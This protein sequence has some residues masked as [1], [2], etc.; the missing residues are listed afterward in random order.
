MHHYY[1]GFVSV[2]EIAKKLSFSAGLLQELALTGSILQLS[3]DLQ[4]R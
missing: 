2:P 4:N 3:T 1:T